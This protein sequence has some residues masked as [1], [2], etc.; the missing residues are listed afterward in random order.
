MNFEERVHMF[1]YKLNDTD[2]QIIEY[3]LQHKKDFIHHSIQTSA[4]AL[5]T[6]LI[7]LHGY[8]KSLA[9]TAFLI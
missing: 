9:M 1:E 6:V 2:D 7:R 3:I 4:A 8:L 5:Y